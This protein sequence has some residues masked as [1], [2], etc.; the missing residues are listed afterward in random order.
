MAGYQA[1]VETKCRPNQPLLIRVF[2][3]SF[4]LTDYF[5][6]IHYLSISLSFDVSP[7]I[8]LPKQGYLNKG[9]SSVPPYIPIE[10]DRYDRNH[11]RHH[12]NN[13]ASIVLLRTSA[14]A[15]SGRRGSRLPVAPDLLNPV[16]RVSQ[17]NPL[18]PRQPPPFQPL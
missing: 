6:L 8:V 4:S 3:I 12:K 9:R 16:L 17:E 18:L 10:Y 2:L 13:R 14:S 11:H 1:K 5:P 7:F 15:S